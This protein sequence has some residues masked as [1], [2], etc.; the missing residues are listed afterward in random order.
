MVEDISVVIPYFNEAHGLPTTLALLAVQTALPKEAILVDSGST[1]G[2]Y[3][4]IER[5]VANNPSEIKFINIRACLGT[6]SASRNLGIRTATGQYVALMDCGLLFEKDWLERQITYLH[7]R[8]LDVVSGVCWFTGVGVLDKMAVAHNYGY[9]RRHATL[10]STLVKRSVFDVTGLFRSGV[11]SHDDLEWVWALARHRITRGVNHDVVILY[12]G[13]N[14]SSSARHLCVKSYRYA[15]A[16]GLVGGHRRYFPYYALLLA[17]PLSLSLVSSASQLLMVAA[18]NS[19]LLGYVLPIYK[20]RGMRLLVEHPSAAIGLPCV[21]LMIYA[22]KVVGL[23]SG[24]V[25]YRVFRSHLEP[26]TKPV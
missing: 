19:V 17:C 23:V 11:R 14:Y 2:S 18:A 22:A 26:Q 24:L 20:S 21:G 25:K 15:L 9:G 13:T 8:G 6:P 16:L 12:N 1:D 3:D 4:V 5:W 7:E 10:P